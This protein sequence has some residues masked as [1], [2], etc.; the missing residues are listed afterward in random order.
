MAYSSEESTGTL[1]LQEMNS[2]E[3]KSNFFLHLNE[4]SQSLKCL[5]TNEYEEKIKSSSN[6]WSTK[7]A[8]KQNTYWTPKVMNKPHGESA[9]IEDLPEDMNREQLSQKCLD[10]MIISQQILSRYQNKD[11]AENNRGTLKS[12]IDEK[13]QALFKND[14]KKQNVLKLLV[15]KHTA[16]NTL[17]PDESG[18]NKVEVVK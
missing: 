14:L 6:Q 8:I 15:A 1:E 5:T 18:F 9:Q 3:A 4:L 11:A 7:E 13:N 2:E 12:R 10:N 16:E 17:R